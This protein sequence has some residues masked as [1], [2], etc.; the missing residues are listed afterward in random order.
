ME[1]DMGIEIGNSDSVWSELITQY[2][3]LTDHYITSL[4]ETIKVSTEVSMKTIELAK[5]HLYVAQVLINSWREMNK[6]D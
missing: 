4:A 5:T 1:K 6:N 3:K 2:L